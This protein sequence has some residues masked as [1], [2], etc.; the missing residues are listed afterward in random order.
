MSKLLSVSELTQYQLLDMITEA[1]DKLGQ[2]YEIINDTGD[3]ECPA[4]DKCA[5]MMMDSLDQLNTAYKTV[6]NDKDLP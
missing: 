2:A 6:Y 1:Q 5:G 3:Y 4:L